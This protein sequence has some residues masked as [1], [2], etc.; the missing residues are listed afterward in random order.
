MGVG[1]VARDSTSK[2]QASIC[3]FLP[4][5]TD[6]AAMEAYAARQG[7]EM[8]RDMGFRKILLEGDAQVIV[9]A[10]NSAGACSARY[11]SIIDDTRDILQ[12]FSSWRVL[13]VRLEW[14]SVAH[15]LARVVVTQCL[16]QV[17]IELLPDSVHNCVS[18]DQ[19]SFS[20]V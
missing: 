12:S 8:S 4:S 2:V 7:A 11:A 19:G 15:S 17:W 9:Q 16:F 18:V 20:L 3:N 1:L 14:N 6:P 5:L 10:I 13:F